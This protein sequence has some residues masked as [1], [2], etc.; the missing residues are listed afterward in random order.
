MF[1]SDVSL[2]TIVQRMIHFLVI[3]MLLLLLHQNIKI[4]CII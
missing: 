3:L 2:F 1:T 4:I